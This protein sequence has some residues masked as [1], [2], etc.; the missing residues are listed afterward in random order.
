MRVGSSVLGK[1]VPLTTSE[2]H[3]KQDAYS[4]KVM[5]EGGQL[6]LLVH[7]LALGV[8]YSV[9]ATRFCRCNV[10]AAVG[11]LQMYGPQ[12]LDV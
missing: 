1:S 11:D 6:F 10:R 3:I 4:Q 2:N 12:T 7:F 8:I 5:E 9:T